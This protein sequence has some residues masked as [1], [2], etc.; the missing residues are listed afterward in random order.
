MHQYLWLL[1]LGVLV[2]AFGT[3]IGAGGGFILMPVLILLYPEQSPVAMT[4]ISLVI[5]FLNAASGTAAYARMRRI[6]YKSGLM[7]SLATVPGAVLGAMATALFP[8]RWFDLL[9]GLL[10]VGASAY[11][12]TSTKPPS[13]RP[14]TTGARRFH[15]A[16]VEPDG[17]RHEWSF[18][19]AVGLW[20]SLLVG[21]VSSLL[22]IGGGIIHVPAMVRLLSFP[23]HI[24]TATSHF[25]LAIMAL[26][27]TGVH[28]LDGAL[29][30]TA[31][32]VIPLAIGVVIGAQFGA[33]LSNRV[34]GRLILVIL[35]LA[36]GAV[37]LRILVAALSAR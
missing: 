26:A 14:R 36:L 33:W 13:I 9:F 16:I 4:A 20:L 32:L 35:A 15:R 2:G 25:V 23:V 19:P 12:L 3:L 11:L 31:G 29:L 28:L 22:G 21:F 8:R 24:A 18:N 27:G 37:G 10:L 30:N 1:P 6:D 7:F 5:V 17:T 34:R